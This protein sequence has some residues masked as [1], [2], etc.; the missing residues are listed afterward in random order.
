MVSRGLAEVI[1]CERS[2]SRRNT[3]TLRSARSCS[4]AFSTAPATRLAI[5]SSIV[6]SDSLNSCGASVCRVSTPSSW[7][8]RP[9]TGTVA[10][11]W[12]RSSFRSGTYR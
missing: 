9:T 1:R 7:P 2:A 10:T 11:D 5:V 3:S 4:C 12:K 6:T 8:E